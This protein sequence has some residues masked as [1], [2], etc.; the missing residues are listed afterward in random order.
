MAEFD[1]I[2]WLRQRTPSDARV[3]VGPGDDA[4]VLASIN[5]PLIVTTD[6]LMDGVD[7]LLAEVD[8]VRVGR[9]AMG[10]NLSDLAAMGAKPLAAVASVALPRSADSSLAE[11]LH[12]GMTEMATKYDC[13]LV[14]GDTNSWDKPLVISVTAFGTPGPQGAIL[15]SGA[16]PGDWLFVTGSLGGSILGRH[17]DV[18]PRVREALELQR[19]VQLHAMIDISDG[20]AADVHHLVEESGCGVVLE[21]DAIAIHA[22]AHRMNEGRSPLEHALG[23]GEDFELAFAVSPEDGELLLTHQPLAACP[24]T[25]IGTF[26]AE[27]GLWIQQHGQRRPLPPMGWVHL[28]GENE[29]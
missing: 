6:M 20:L 26:V 18:K 3:Q 24:V 21:A 12:L 8:P 9:K 10:V 14:G 23:D 7:F 19:H 17:L 5:A 25:C 13:P 1:F 15:R 16:K 11:Q 4:A 27:R 2:R 28:L 22:D 29:P